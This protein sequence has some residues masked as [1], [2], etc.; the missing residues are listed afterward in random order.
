ME[1]NTATATLRLWTNNPF[2]REKYYERAVNSSAYRGD[3]GIDLFLPEDV[4][5]KKPST[6]CGMAQIVN[7][8]VKCEMI[9]T[10]GE[11]IS[12][13][14]FER[15]STCLKFPISLGN[16]TG[17][18]DSG[19]RDYVGALLRNT[20]YHNEPVQLKQGMR[21]VQICHPSLKRLRLELVSEAEDL[22]SSERGE[23]GFGSSGF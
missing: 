11:P 9:D 8:Q 1:S 21:I 12:Y 3:A 13:K 14:L 5:I 15:S 10:N 17:I 18:I 6:L 22:S 20:N 4:V 16:K 23:R 19:Y 2:L 7:L